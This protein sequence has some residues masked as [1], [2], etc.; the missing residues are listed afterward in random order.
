MLISEHVITCLALV[1]IMKMQRCVWMRVARRGAICSETKRVESFSM[2]ALKKFEHCVWREVKWGQI[3]FFRLP[4]S[5]LGT[6]HFESFLTFYISEFCSWRSTW[7]QTRSNN[8]ITLIG[9]KVGIRNL[10]NKDYEMAYFLFSSTK[11]KKKSHFWVFTVFLKCIRF[12][13][14]FGIR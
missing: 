1:A 3:S 10:L 9:F 5:N 8:T 6:W 14:Y 2:Q 12:R 4:R 11:K 13:W 7:G